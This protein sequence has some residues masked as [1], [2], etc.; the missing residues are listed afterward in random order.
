[1]SR[2]SFQSLPLEI[3]EYVLTLVSD[4]HTLRSAVL[5][6]KCVHNTFL[7]RRRTIMR[8]VGL[9][10]IGPALPW[11]FA[12]VRMKY[13]LE[14]APLQVVVEGL[15]DTSPDSAYWNID[16]GGREAKALPIVS[17]ATRRLESFFCLLRKDRTAPTSTLSEVESLRFHRAIYRTWIITVLLGDDMHQLSDIV[18][19]GIKVFT[20][21]CERELAELHEVML[22]LGA[23]F[24]KIPRSGTK[25]FEDFRDANPPLNV[26]PDVALASMT[27]RFSPTRSLSR[28]PFFNGVNRFKRTAIE[29]RIGKQIGKKYWR[30][31]ILTRYRVET[32]Q[33]CQKCGRRNAG[34]FGENNWHLL[35]R[36]LEFG[37]LLN[38]LPGRIPGNK[39]LAGE[40]RRLLSRQDSLT[41]LLCE[42]FDSQNDPEGRWKKSDWLCINCIRNFWKESLLSWIVDQLVEGEP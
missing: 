38:C 30:R 26:V 4:Y 14:E 33:R 15:T 31:S 9:N 5:S 32:I 28:L 3:R 6:S 40:I 39:Y 41:F 36:Y 27:G 2:G 13:A 7:P 25:L 19:K 37:L 21:L 10:E 8:E 22:F 12:L 17:A 11:A 34:L 35:H 24:S 42:L 18:I 29:Q 23:M 16:I 1:M 20:D